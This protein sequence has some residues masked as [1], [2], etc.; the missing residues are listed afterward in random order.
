MVFGGEGCTGAITAPRGL[1]PP[2]IRQERCPG[3][4]RQQARL[5]VRDGR[6]CG[7]RMNAVPRL[8]WPLPCVISSASMLQ[9]G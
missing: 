6:A 5:A 3:L 4:V 7:H 8:R 2:L 1:L 9:K